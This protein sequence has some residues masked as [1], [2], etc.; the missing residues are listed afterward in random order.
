MI[1]DISQLDLKRLVRRHGSIKTPRRTIK[2]TSY[3]EVSA[4]IRMMETYRQDWDSLE[5]FRERYRR[6]CRFHRGD[7]WSDMT[8]DDDGNPIK[9][10]DYIRA[11][12]K[13]PLKQNIMRPLA[14]SLE[15]L[16][17]SERGKSIVI[18]RKPDS[19]ASFFS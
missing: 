13:L 5:E 9:E 12:G 16:F 14:K 19:S 17:R 3:S 1:T 18:S 4:N 10:E 11:Q 2:E 8:T 15:G 7:Q 6:V